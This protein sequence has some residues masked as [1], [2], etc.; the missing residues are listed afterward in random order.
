MNGVYVIDASVVAKWYL[1]DEEAADKA[2]SLLL[3]FARGEVA[4]TAPSLL[5]YEVARALQRAYGQRR[6]PFEVARERLNDLLNLNLR[7]VDEVEVLRLAMGLAYRYGRNFY[8]ACYM[9]LAELLGVPLLLADE[10]LRR[11]LAGR[12]DY[13]LPLDRLEIQS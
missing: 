3:A 4:L 5:V 13:L 10:R 9:A 1:I 8:D 12:V 11:Q 6:I 2:A 7:L